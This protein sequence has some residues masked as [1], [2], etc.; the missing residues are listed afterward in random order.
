M[1]TNTFKAFLA[2]GI[3]FLMGIL[4]TAQ[5]SNLTIEQIRKPGLVKIIDSRPEFG[6]TLPAT[7][8]YQTGYQI[9]LSSTQSLIQQDQG[10]IWDSGQIWSNQSV[11]VALG[12]AALAENTTYFWKVRYYDVDGKA[13]EYSKVQAFQTG[14]FSTESTT[15]NFTQIEKIKPVATK[16]LD[17]GSYFID[18][19]KA[20]FA[21]LEINYQPRRKE[22]LTIRVGEK[23]LD[24]KIDQKPGGT[25]RFQEIKV[26]VH[27]KQSLYHINFVPD[28]RNTNEKAVALPDSFPVLIPYRYLEV[29]GA[30]KKFDPNATTQVA[31]FNY[32][33]STTSNFNSSD[34]I[35][36]QV[37][38]ICKYSMK[39][40]TFAGY[41]V[42]G[43]RERIPYEADAY[44]NQLSHY[45]VDNEYAIARKTIEY[46]FDSKPTWP[47]EWQL[48]VAMMMYQD[49]MHTG[50]TELIEKYYER[51]KAK[52]LMALEV[53]DGFI[54]TESPKH[55][56]DLLLSL[57]FPDTTRKLRDIVDWPPES[58][59]FGGI[60][61]YQKGER[62]G[63]VFKRINTVVNG[64]YFHNMNIMAEFAI[65]LQ[66]PD[67]ALDFAYRAARV[68]K[69]IN[70]QLFDEAKG[71]Y[72]D[73]VGTDHGSLHANMIL[74]AFDA[75]PESRKRRVVEHVKSRGMACSVYGA[76]YLMEALYQGGEDQYAH[77]LM[78]ATHDRSWY[79]MIK[80]GSTI[81]LEAW[82]MKYKVNADWNH[83]WGAAPANII[84]RFM[85][86][87][88][89][90]TPG[91]GKVRIQPQMGALT[92]CSLTYPTT[93]GPIKT[94]FK[95]T[96]QQTDYTIE[97]PANMIAELVLDQPPGQQHLLNGQSFSML[98][99]S[100]QLYPGKNSI[101]IKH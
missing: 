27:P 52:T 53:E 21:S 1:Q 10:D 14:V 46:F 77:E 2:L 60:K 40:T 38:D 22:I 32:F 41:Y 17:H 34:P 72:V 31:Y 63:Y 95:K 15:S 9:L 78:S 16:K 47:T 57:G 42:D 58:N 44:L 3:L 97:I 29:A 55:N 93:R 5:P 25:I 84:P 11:E 56:G 43:E 12:A 66:K 61:R 73:G 70:E 89:P 100:I 90:L 88:Q 68:K 20:A 62:D 39:A 13:S 50:N 82:D 75:V 74:L 37:W 8:E 67:E 99:E 26:E 98:H 85:W 45:A 23:L 36:N 64:F 24:G 79:N 54:S 96:D 51:L 7:A 30:G 19:G 65:V 76:Q 80:I 6:W 83:A 33:D 35:L 101:T 28:D 92:S 69:S 71:Y 18:F 87:I 4:V 94:T 81:T 49:Y 59:N 48:H 86:G 91:F